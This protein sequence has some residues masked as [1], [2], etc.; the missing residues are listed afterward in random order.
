MIP[1][2]VILTVPYDFENL[3]YFAPTTCTPINVTVVKMF[4]CDEMKTEY[5]TTYQSEWIAIWK[6]QETGASLVEHPFAAN[7]Q[8]SIA[9][10]DVND[11]P[12]NVLQDITCNTRVPALQY[13]GWS[14]F[15]GCQVWSTCFFDIDMIED[16][17]QN[18][19]SRYNRGYHFL[20]ACSI[21]AGLS[22]VFIVAYLCLMNRKGYT[23][24]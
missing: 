17:Q 6:C 4:N 18:A 13:P 9:K 7:P 14:N 10:N 5:G 20:I 19:Q 21:F 16:L 15:F 1:A 22:V 23:N 3:P 11:Y 8:E 24:V 12:L 2:V